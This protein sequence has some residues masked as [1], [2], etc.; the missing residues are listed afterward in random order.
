MAEARVAGARR[1]RRAESGTVLLL[2]PAA[3]LV[4][5]VLGAIAV[6]SGVTFMA[7]RNLVAAAGDAAN[8]AG[9]LALDDPQLLGHGNVRLRP[10]QV[11]ESVR[12]VLHRD[13]ID[14]AIIEWVRVSPDGRSARVRVRRTVRLVF[15][16][17]VPG[18]S[19]TATVHATVEVTDRDR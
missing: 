6:D 10:E 19:H 4:V 8:D 5:L 14:D 12:R 3:V 16:P 2:M 7:Q 1:R 18:V 17:V 15:A 13:G 9:S 11:A